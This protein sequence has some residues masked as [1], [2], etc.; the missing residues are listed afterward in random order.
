MSSLSSTRLDLDSN[1]IKPITICIIGAGGFIGSH[2]SEKFMFQTPPK[3]LALDVYN[4]KLKHL[5]E[6]ETLPWNNRIES[7]RLNI[8]RDSKLEG[9]IKIADLV[10]NLAAILALPLIT[11][12]V[13][14]HDLQ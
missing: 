3:V 2:L 1:P 12:H 8:K 10:I 14:C 5:L 7:P 4:D 13:T 9:L 6:L 11:R